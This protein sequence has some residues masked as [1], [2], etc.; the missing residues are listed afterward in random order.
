MLDG[1]LPAWRVISTP[2]STDSSAGS[3]LQSASSVSIVTSPSRF[4]PPAAVLQALAAR[5]QEARESRRAGRAA[6][7]DESMEYWDCAVQRAAFLPD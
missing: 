5:R 4:E 3:P 2:S 6:L 7:W 1:G